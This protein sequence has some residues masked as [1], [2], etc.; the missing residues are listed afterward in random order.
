MSENEIE[1]ALEL[2][3]MADVVEE[4]NDPRYSTRSH[5]TRGTYAEK[6]RG[7][8][9]RRAERLGSR[10]RN[11]VKAD[12]AG[13]PYQESIHRLYDRDALLD[14]ITLWHKMQMAIRRVQNS[15]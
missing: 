6:C 10:K 2:P 1:K 11:K 12:R 13:R 14:E 8:L 7:P 3:E 4:L 5:G 15:A 9:C